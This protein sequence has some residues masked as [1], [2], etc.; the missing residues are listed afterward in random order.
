MRVMFYPLLLFV[1]SVSNFTAPVD[2]T[3]PYIA[4]YYYDVRWGY[5]DEFIRLYK[6]NHYP[7]LKAQMDEDRIL[8]V[9]TYQPQ[10]HGE[11]KADWHFLAVITYRNF[12]AVIDTSGQPALLR[13]LFPDQETFRK[14]EQRRFELLEAHWD[15]PLREV[16][17][18]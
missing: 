11:G 9:K 4:H 15:M 17:M 8:S 2:R 13:R 6:K 1:S 7:F 12:E 3:T 10:F 16:P 14:E 5:V 18:E